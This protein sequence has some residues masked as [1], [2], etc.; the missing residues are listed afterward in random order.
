MKEIYSKT[1][2]AGTQVSYS[3]DSIMEFMLF[4]HC[5]LFKWISMKLLIIKSF[6]TVWEVVIMTDKD[7]TIVNFNLN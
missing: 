6:I 5:F 7:I 2:D 3:I 1:V 4:K